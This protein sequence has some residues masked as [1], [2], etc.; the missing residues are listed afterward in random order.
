MSTVTK[1]VTCPECEELFDL[2]V[3]TDPENALQDVDCPECGAMLIATYDPATQTVTLE[4]AE[5]DEDE[6]D[7]EDDELPEDA[8]AD[9]EDQP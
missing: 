8:E 6:L 9:E 3:D 2:E 4:E 1:E 5:D 7:G